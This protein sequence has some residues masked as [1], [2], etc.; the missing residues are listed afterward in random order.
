V[1]GAKLST[2]SLALSNTVFS[3]MIDNNAIS[4][5]CKFPSRQYPLLTELDK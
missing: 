2:Q 5:N 4:Y 3:R 1:L